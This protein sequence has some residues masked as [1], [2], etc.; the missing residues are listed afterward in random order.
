[1]NPKEK[2]LL[3][4]AAIIFL[5]GFIP[6]KAAP[7]A[8]KYINDEWKDYKKLKQD[9]EYFTTI[10]ERAEFWQEENKRIKKE[11]DEIRTKAL[12]GRNQELIHSK[13]ENRLREL[14]LSTGFSVQSWGLPEFYQT[15]DW[16]FISKEIQFRQT[17][18]ATLLRFLQAIDNVP[19]YLA[20]LNLDVRSNRNRLDGNV[21]VSGFAY[22]PI[23]VPS[24][25]N[26]ADAS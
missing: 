4:M 14:S 22:L 2:R 15:G 9:I 16:L 6:F 19:E 24:E 20:L 26:L 8:W 12:P 17:D 21:R 18:P 23:P 7:T 10:K 13:M 1:M 25:D 11:R 3:K 5:A